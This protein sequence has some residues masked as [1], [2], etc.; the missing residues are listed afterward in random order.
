METLYILI[1]E[2]VVRHHG[3]RWFKLVNFAAYE[4]DKISNSNKNMRS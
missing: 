2:M 3:T 1:V 4:T